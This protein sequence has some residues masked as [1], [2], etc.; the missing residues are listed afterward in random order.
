MLQQWYCCFAVSSR[1][2]LFGL[3]FSVWFWL[4]VCMSCVNGANI[5]ALCGWL[6]LSTGVG[7][8]FSVNFYPSTSSSKTPCIKNRTKRVRWLGVMLLFWSCSVR[9]YNACISKS[10]QSCMGFLM[11]ILEECLWSWWGVL[12]IK[13]ILFKFKNHYVT[14][15]FVDL[16][17]STAQT[18]CNRGW[19]RNMVFATYWKGAKTYTAYD[20]LS[21]FP[22][23]SRKWVQYSIMT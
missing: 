13:I 3:F 4:L 16:N 1:L 5:C 14:L 17:L 23:K 15:L 11:D 22:N 7:G 12:L 18:S 9:H 2:S 6:T 19:I 20:I 10:T 21:T 8:S